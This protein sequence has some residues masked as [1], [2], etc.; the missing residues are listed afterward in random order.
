MTGYLPTRLGWVLPLAADELLASWVWRMEAYF[1]APGLLWAGL[2][3]CPEQLDHHPPREALHWLSGLTGHSLT[4]LEGR[5]RSC[6]SVFDEVVPA[7]CLACLQE[8][9]QDPNGLYLRQ[10]WGNGLRTLCSRHKHPLVALPSSGSGMFRWRKQGGCDFAHGVN[11]ILLEQASRS[12]PHATEWEEL[13]QFE[14]AIVDGGSL[15][16]WGGPTTAEDTAALLKT[17]IPVL[18][19]L[20]SGSVLDVERL[21]PWVFMRPSRLQ[22]PVTCENFGAQPPD[23]RRMFLGA[24]MAT[25]FS[26]PRPHRS[27]QQRRTAELEDYSGGGAGGALAQRSFEHDRRWYRLKAEALLASPAGHDVLRLCGRAQRKA[28]GA[29]MRSGLTGKGAPESHDLLSNSR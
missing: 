16:K 1:E 21:I 7:A 10:D 11:R 20:S 5:S 4:D 19:Q 27:G 14:A 9:E 17:L 25:R 23:I 24:L 8:M 12:W 3:C 22:G 6:L 15:E 18:G 29:L 13:A 28:L 26:P 2:G